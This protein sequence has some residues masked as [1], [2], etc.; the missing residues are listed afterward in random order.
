MRDLEEKERKG[1]GDQA[2]SGRT[3]SCDV[4]RIQNGRNQSTQ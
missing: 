2:R 1:E 3:S 4:K